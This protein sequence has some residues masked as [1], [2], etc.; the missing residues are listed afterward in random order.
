MQWAIGPDKIVTGD[1]KRAL[2]GLSS[3]VDPAF[4]D[5]RFVKPDR[6]P[7]PDTLARMQVFD[8]VFLGKAGG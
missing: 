8:F 1:D 2:G 7:L 4:E 5:K 3:A 6:F